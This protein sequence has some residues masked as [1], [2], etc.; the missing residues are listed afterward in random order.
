MR[1]LFFSGKKYQSQLWVG[2]KAE[3]V[4]LVIVEED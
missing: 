4:I 3:K 1:V 2:K